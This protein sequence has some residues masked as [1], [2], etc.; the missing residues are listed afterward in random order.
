VIIG[1]C[2]N[3]SSSKEEMSDFIQAGADSFWLEV[4]NDP[5]K[6]IREILEKWLVRNVRLNPSDTNFNKI[7]AEL[8][9]SFDTNDS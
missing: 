9:T 2:L 1:L 3:P 4:Q 7:L 8:I 5:A 6:C